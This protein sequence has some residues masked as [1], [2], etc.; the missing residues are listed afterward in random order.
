VT[1][2]ASAITATGATLNGAVN[3]GGAS[4]LSS[5]QYGTTTAYGNTTAPHRLAVAHTS[6][7][8]SANIGGLTSGTTYHFRAVVTTDFGT[9]VGADRTF[10]TS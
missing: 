4:A 9:F 7:P 8:F 5:F 10:T 3:P 1:N 6:T 2:P